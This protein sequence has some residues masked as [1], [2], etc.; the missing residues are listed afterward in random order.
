MIVC[1][2]GFWHWKEPL[3]APPIFNFCDRETFVTFSQRWAFGHGYGLVIGSSKKDQYVTLVCDRSGRHENTTADSDRKRAN[4]SRKC[5]CTFAIKALRGSK[6]GAVWWMKIITGDHN[7]SP[8]T[9]PSSHPVH[10]WLSKVEKEIV[11]D[12]I[13]ES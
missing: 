8:S 6:E 5:G 2:V 4:F 13:G 9:N 11:R 10:R 12:S 3:S 1:Y 7:H